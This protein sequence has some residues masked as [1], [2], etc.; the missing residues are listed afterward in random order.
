MANSEGCASAAGFL[1]DWRCRASKD[2][3][4]RRAVAQVLPL[5][6]L[7]LLLRHCYCIA[8]PVAALLLVLL[9]VIAFVVI[10]AAIA[11]AIAASAAAIAA[12]L[13]LL[14]PYLGAILGPCWLSWATGGPCWGCL[15]TI[16]EPSWAILGRARGYFEVISCLSWA[17]SSWEH[18]A[19]PPPERL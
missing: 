19:S 13:L 10:V 7:L 8:I 14:L 1:S 12:P 17:M 2:R 18:L 9:L 16:L 3:W 15:G 11:I 6:L 5:V 4:S